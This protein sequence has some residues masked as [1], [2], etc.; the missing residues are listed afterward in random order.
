V[1]TENQPSPVSEADPVSSD[2][3]VPTEA[4]LKRVLVTLQDTYE[5]GVEVVL[6]R[7]AAS[8]VDA[9][10][11]DGTAPVGVDYE[12]AGRYARAVRHISDAAEIVTRKIRQL[13][14]Y[15]D[16]IEDAA[17]DGHLETAPPFDRHGAGSYSPSDEALERWHLTRSQSDL[18]EGKGGQS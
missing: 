1:A 16:H 12:Y 5:W 3:G 6:H 15:R 9:Y 8:F 17:G 13:E 18:L 7:I 10:E 11:G 4:E 14:A 2:G